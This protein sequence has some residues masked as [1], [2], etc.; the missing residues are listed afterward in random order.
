MEE[1]QRLLNTMDIPQQRRTDLGWL[2]RNIQ[3][4]NGSHPQ[5]NETVELIK[6][7]TKKGQQQ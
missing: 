7:L 2:A 5:I 3:V 6:K 1:L 4:N